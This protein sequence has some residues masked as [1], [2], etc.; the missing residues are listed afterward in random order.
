MILILG[1]SGQVA[2]R[3][4]ETFGDQA[5]AWGRNDLDLATC[6]RDELRAKLAG[7]ASEQ[8]LKL[9]I[10]A[11]AYTAVDRAETEVEACRRLNAVIPG[12]VGEIARENSVPVIQYSTD[13]VYS[14]EGSSPQSET[15]LLRPAGVYA[16][17]KREGELSLLDSGARAL[18]LRVAWVY[19]AEGTNF[20]RTMLRLGRDRSE[21]RVVSDQVG[22]PTAAR[23]IAEW[24]AR[25]APWWMRESS[26]SLILNLAPQ[27]FVSWHGFA[28]QIFAVAREMKHPIKLESVEAIATT[29]YPTPANRPLNSRLDCRQAD[30]LVGQLIGE[31]PHWSA[32]LKREMEFVRWDQLS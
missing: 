1:R 20:L 23:R 26:K 3:L 30:Q 32:D 8:K 27:G 12:W 25:V 9:I 10:N 14:G 17:T 5:R 19:D 24:T 28:E 15:S 2:R 21:L 18:I 4:L 31:R 6:T 11:A 29:E 13:Y 7:L 16:L 22:A